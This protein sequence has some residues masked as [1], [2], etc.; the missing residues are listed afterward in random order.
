MPF[1]QTL[2]A[3]QKR[4]AW[5]KLV[6]E[7]VLTLGPLT[8]LTKPDL[9]AAADAVQAYLWAERAAINTALPEPFKSQASTDQKLALLAIVAL[10]NLEG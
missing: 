3:D 8:G 4:R 10:A 7:H 6:R 2:T 5:T 9:E 1:T